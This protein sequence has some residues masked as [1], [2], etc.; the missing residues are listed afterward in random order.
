M[1]RFWLLLIVLATF[2]AAQT[3]PK[4]SKNFNLWKQKYRKSYSNSGTGKNESAAEK[5]YY[6]N[7][8]KI[9]KHNSNK[10]ATYKQNANSNA[11]LTSN[12]AKKSRRGYKPSAKKSNETKNSKTTSKTKSTLKY[13]NQK[14]SLNANLPTSI[15]YTRLCFDFTLSVNY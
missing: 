1:N 14:S 3:T 4:T 15:D 2:V 13:K 11:D 8:A 7:A 5:V 12:E 6:Q 9:E 10:N